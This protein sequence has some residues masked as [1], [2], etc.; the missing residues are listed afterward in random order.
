[1]KTTRKVLGKYWES[2][3]KLLGKYW[4]ST[5]KVL[6]KYWE[7]T[8]KLLGKYWK[9]TWKVLGKWWESDEKVLGNYWKSTGK[10]IGKWLESTGKESPGKCWESEFFPKI[11]LWKVDVCDIAHLKVATWE[12]AFGNIPLTLFWDTILGPPAWLRE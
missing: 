5:G 6:G 2:T 9:S 8:G 10:V 4:E 11:F 3:G 7:S 12:I 1:M